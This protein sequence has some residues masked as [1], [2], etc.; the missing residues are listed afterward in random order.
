[1]STKVL[2]GHTLEVRGNHAV[3]VG[4][5]AGKAESDQIVHGS[6]T[7]AAEERLTLRAD[8]GVSLVCGKARID[9]LPDRIALS[10]PAIDLRCKDAVTTSTEDGPVVTVGK[11]F[12]I[13]S[14]KVRVF[15]EGAAIELDQDA[16]IK[17]AKIQ[18]GYHPDK[19]SKEHR[20]ADGETK[21]LTLKLSDWFLRPYAGKTYHLMVE[22]L[23][24]EG[25]TD[26]EGTLRERVPKSAKQAV[27]RLWIRDYP[28]GE[29]RLYQLRLGELAP[30][31][32]VK[33][34]EQRLK[35]L[36]YY[37]GPIGRGMGPELRAAI[38]EFQY[39]HADTHGLEPTG[40][41]DAGTCGAIEEIFGS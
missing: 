9:L 30:A 41:A 38:Q 37:T 16:K 29:T 14:K 32:D 35:N 18:L 2:S 27:L 8:A 23:R 11:E 20:D 1:M 28:E 26:A 15:S 34:I 31:R 4:T 10:A 33:G 6:A 13:L 7:I 24:F 3:V 19:P 22:G 17:G 40:D 5:P 21:G 36:G 39:D 25:T 12:E